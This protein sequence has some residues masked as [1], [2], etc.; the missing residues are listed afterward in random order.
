MTGPRTHAD[1]DA[2]SHY[3]SAIGR[4]R[5]ELITPA[6]VLDLDMTERNIRSMADRLR[7]LPAKL[8]PHIKVHKS[9]EIARMQVEAGA[10][11]VATATVAEAVAMS[12]S[13]IKDVLI[14]NQVVGR[15]KIARIVRA[16]VDAKMTLAV[17][18][19]RNAEEI[20]AAARS[21]GSEVGV[22]IEVDVGMGRGGAR[23][24]E[25]ARALAR[26]VVGL[27]GLR[28]R[29]VQGYEGHCMLEPDRQVRMSK[30]RAAMDLLSSVVDLLRSDGLVCDVVSAGGTGTYDIT[31][32][33]PRVTEIQAGSYVFM[34]AF[35]G[36]LVAGFVPALTVLATV[37]SHHGKTIVL[38]AGRKAVGVDFAPARMVGYDYGARYFAEEHTLFD[39]DARCDLRLG[40]TVAM[41]P[42]YGPTTVNLYDA[43]HVVRDGVVVD[44]WPIVARGSGDLYPRV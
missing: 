41:I 15:D 1:P 30:A 18:D 17:D 29:G 44:I 33:D 32:A 10:I 21:V 22:L 11:G 4:R 12:A 7:A 34:D 38:D 36:S 16:A 35:H 5:D 2:R 27:R 20:A 13:G 8:R 19:A 28:F 31:G 25:E 42:G 40:D 43:Y 14:A 39:V 26:S 6:L 9:P 3:R 37:V 24:A 23:S